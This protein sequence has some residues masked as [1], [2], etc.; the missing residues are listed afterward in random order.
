MK[1]SSDYSN[2]DSY[3]KNMEIPP[4]EISGWD[5]DFWT[6]YKDIYSDVTDSKYD[7]WTPYKDIYSDVTDSKYEFCFLSTLHIHINV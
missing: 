5:F 6:P 2:F 7:F 4:D 3:P 1:G